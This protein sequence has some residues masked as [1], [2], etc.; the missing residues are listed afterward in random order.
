MFSLLKTYFSQGS[1][2]WAIR[3]RLV[4]LLTIFCCS[5][6]IWAL[7]WIESDSRSENAVNQAF[8]IL[9]GILT[10]YIGGVVA[11]EALKSRSPGKLEVKTETK[12]T[13]VDSRQ[14]E[15]KAGNSPKIQPSG[16]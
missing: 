3:R 11:D 8:F 4:I 13:I 2:E 16:D 15:D 10:V 9:W 1:Q 12:E 5:I 14:T 6:I 7:G